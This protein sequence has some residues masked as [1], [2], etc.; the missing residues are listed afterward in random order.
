MFEHLEL[1]LSWSFTSSQVLLRPSFFLKIFSDPL[2][3]YK[4]FW[5]NLHFTW[6]VFTAHKKVQ[7]N[8][9]KTET[10][11]KN[12]PYSIYLWKKYQNLLHFSNPHRKLLEFDLIFKLLEFDL[13]FYSTLL[14]WFQLCSCYL[15]HIKFYFCLVWNRYG[16]F[17]CHICKW[18]DKKSNELK[19]CWCFCLRFEF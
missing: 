11:W 13:I 17:T 15:F 1:D 19:H 3:F 4:L 10:D 14:H 6:G 2:T 16:N 9:L 7:Q 8:L 18:V 5:L 12:V